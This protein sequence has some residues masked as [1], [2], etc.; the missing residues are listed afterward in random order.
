M[1]SWTIR[2]G[3]LN[4]ET[5]NSTRGKQLEIQN[6][7]A[8]PMY[9]GEKAYFDVGII[10]TETVE[11]TQTIQPI[12]L[13]ANASIELDKYARNYMEIVGKIQTNFFN[14]N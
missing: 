6:Y 2:V 9:D 4:L 7:L 14:Q 8:H 3:D 5:R 11:F 1:F 12:C 13:P 10:I